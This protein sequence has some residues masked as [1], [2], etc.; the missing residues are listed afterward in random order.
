VRIRFVALSCAGAAAAMVA[1]VVPAVAAGGITVTS[2]GCAGGGSLY[3]F[4]PEAASGTVGTAVTWTNTT[5]AP[6]TVTKCDTTACPGAP[7]SSGSDS[8]NA[9]LATG[10]GSTAS[11]TFT[12]PGTYVYYCTVHGYAAMHGT[13]TV[14]AAP[15]SPTP[16]PAASATA[17]PSGGGAT[18]PGAGAGLGFSGALVLLVGSA[19]VV[20]GVAAL[21]RQRLRT[22]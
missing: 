11:V 18:V 2:G 14:A 13:I 3:C 10:S 16:S 7:A 1:A 15:A 20:A 19:L 8:F 17:A 22:D 12:S 4:S 9:N 5:S 21:R 6:H